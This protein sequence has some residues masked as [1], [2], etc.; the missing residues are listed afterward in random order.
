MKTP[1]LTEE[2]T[3]HAARLAAELGDSTFEKVCD[4]VLSGETSDSF[5]IGMIQNDHRYAD[6]MERGRNLGWQ[7]RPA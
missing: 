2:Q 6:W 1:H 5:L 4:E 3:E 7:V